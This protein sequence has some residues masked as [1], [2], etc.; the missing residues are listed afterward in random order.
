MEPLD[1]PAHYLTGAVETETNLDGGNEETE[2][3]MDNLKNDNIQALEKLG[4]H[5]SFNSKQSNMT[6]SIVNHFLS[7]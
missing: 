2:E 5:K 6:F 3:R 7:L 4:R 1:T